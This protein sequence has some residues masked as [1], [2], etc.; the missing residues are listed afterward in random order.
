MGSASAEENRSQVRWT[1][2]SEASLI[3]RDWADHYVVYNAGSGHTH[4]LDPIGALALREI[5]V[6]PLTMQEM[7]NRLKVLLGLESVEEFHSKLQQLLVQFEELG[8]VEPE[9]P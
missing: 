5:Q 6:H 4:V 7:A 1:V 2:P 9:V 8:L 3:W